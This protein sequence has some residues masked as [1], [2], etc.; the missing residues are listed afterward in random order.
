MGAGLVEH[1]SRFRIWG[2][3]FRVWD[4]GF[5]A[6]GRVRQK[7]LKGVRLQRVYGSKGPKGFK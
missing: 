2:L 5:G 7:G 4:L 1:D 3:G 6:S